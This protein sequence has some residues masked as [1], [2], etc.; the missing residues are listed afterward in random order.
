MRALLQ[1]TTSASVTVDG[2]VVGRLDRP[3]LVVLLGVSVED[4]EAEACQ[5]AAKVAGLRVLD[6]EQ[7]LLSAGA[8]ALVVSQFTLYGDVRKGRRPSWTRSAPAELAEPLYERFTAELAGQGIHVE[9]GVFG[10]MMELS[11]VNSGPFTVWVD[12]DDLTG[13]RRG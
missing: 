11:L 7:S 8:G 12:T 2:E 3:G 5:L 13:S 1:R 9:R 10:A 6:D 4:T